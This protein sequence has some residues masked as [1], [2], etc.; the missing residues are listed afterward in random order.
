MSLGVGV[1]VTSR[2]V[3]FGIESIVIFVIEES[4]SYTQM[5]ACSIVWINSLLQTFGM[6]AGP[7]ES[8]IYITIVYTPVFQIFQESTL[9]KHLE[10][11]EN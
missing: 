7:L 4:L 6:G 5:W 9:K 10:H 8:L 11:K 1:E 2:V 3:F